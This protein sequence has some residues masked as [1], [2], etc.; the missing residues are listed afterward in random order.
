MLRIG[1]S[2]MHAYACASTWHT[3]PFPPRSFRKPRRIS[4][5][6]SMPTCACRCGIR[7]PSTL[8]STPP[9]SL[10][11]PQA[12]ATPIRIRTSSTY[13]CVA[14]ATTSSSPVPRSPAA[15]TDTVTLS[16]PPPPS[17]PSTMAKCCFVIV[18]PT[19][20]ATTATM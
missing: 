8:T 20:V 7:A 5:S 13:A 1:A 15:P 6:F 10:F 11:L 9:S 3:R 2:S 17:R 18:S 4:P 16:P 14:I 19:T 12:Q